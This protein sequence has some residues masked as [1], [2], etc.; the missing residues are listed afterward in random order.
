[1]NPTVIAPIV[2][3]ITRARVAE[4]GAPTPI[5]T[6]N[7]PRTVNHRAEPAVQVAGVGA[8]AALMVARRETKW[9]TQ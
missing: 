8:I 7:S 2:A 4:A 6:P 1:M 9:V 3:P 5:P